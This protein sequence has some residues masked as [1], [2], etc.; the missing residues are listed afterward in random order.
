MRIAL[1]LSLLFAASALSAELPY[2][3]DARVAKIARS[4][5]AFRD[6]R[7]QQAENLENY[8]A[9]M[10][11]GA[12][13]ADDDSLV[14]TC[15]EEHAH[16]NCAAMTGRARSRCA[17]ISDVIVT[18]QVNEKQFVSRE[19]RFS[20]LQKSGATT[21]SSAYSKIVLRKYAL[22]T[23]EFLLSQP[24]CQDDACL[25]RSIDDYCLKH[26]D[27]RNLPWQGCAASIIWFLGT[28]S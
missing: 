14:A 10:A 25:A 5:Q 2:A 22:V 17:M 19:E 16:R 23:T 21:F 4:L 27:I 28:S 11:R 7:G 3:K 1:L 15:L 8:L 20:L 12:C 18:N 24:D 6:A 13:R 9:S 26:A